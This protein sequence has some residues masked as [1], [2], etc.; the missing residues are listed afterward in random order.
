MK[1]VVKTLGVFLVAVLCISAFLLGQGYGARRAL[2]GLRP[3][4][5]RDTVWRTKPAPLST[6]V[7][8]KVPT[9]YFFDDTTLVDSEPVIIRDSIPMVVDVVRRQYGDS[10][11]YASVSG[12]AIGHLVPSLDSIAVF[13]TTTYVPYPAEHVPKLW[14][15]GPE[16]SATV[17]SG[18]P[19]ALTGLDV[20]YEKGRLRLD[21]SVGYDLFGQKPAFLVRAKWDLIR[22]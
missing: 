18:V 22:F 8:G 19:F 10:T 2:K 1:P 16:L 14:H 3:I 12:P 7:I 5:V 9:F 6:I 13:R 21:G 4:T 11:F 20:S 15:V 17:V